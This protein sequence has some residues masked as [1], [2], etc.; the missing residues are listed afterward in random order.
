MKNITVALDDDTYRRA[1]IVA[2]QRDSSVS[3]LVKRFL[4][5]LAA[6]S[7]SPKSLKDEQ[8]IILN[9]IWDRHPGFCASE[10]LSRNELHDCDA[11]R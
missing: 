10:N 3:A 5:S 7:P 11:V 9:A 1:R 4:M 2:A 8:E 6:E